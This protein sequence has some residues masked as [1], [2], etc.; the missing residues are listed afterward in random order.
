MA[1]LSASFHTTGNVETTS[2]SQ[3][4]NPPPNTTQEEIEQVLKRLLEEATISLHDFTK[5]RLD[6]YI[7][8]PE[9]GKR[10]CD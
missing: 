7:A 8:G 10:S 1:T 3:A 4:P 5:T 9:F 6:E 2:S